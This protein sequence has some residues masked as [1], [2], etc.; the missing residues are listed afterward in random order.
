MFDTTDRR[1]RYMRSSHRDIYR[2]SPYSE[3]YKNPPKISRKRYLYNIPKYHK[4]HPRELIESKMYTSG[5]PHNMRD[6]EILSLSRMSSDSL[7]IPY[8]IEK[9]N[10]KK[11]PLVVTSSSVLLAQAP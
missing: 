8:H 10:H 5:R 7:D 6:P 3:K 4:N 1:A 2:Q 9:S 11:N